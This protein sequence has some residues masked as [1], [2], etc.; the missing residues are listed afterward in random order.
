MK[1]ATKQ[2]CSICVNV[3][4][5]TPARSGVDQMRPL[6]PLSYPLCYIPILTSAKH[7][8]PFPFKYLQILPAIQIIK[9]TVF[10]S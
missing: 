10:R 7:Y 2:E 9:E 5:F 4:F 1:S 3:E 6:T 8:M